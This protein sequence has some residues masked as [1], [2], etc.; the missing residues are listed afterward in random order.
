MAFLTFNTKDEFM[1]I[2]YSVGDTVQLSA[3]DLESDLSLIESFGF[4]RVD[5]GSNGIGGVSLNG[6]NYKLVDNKNDTIIYVAFS[7]P[8]K[9]G[10]GVAYMINKHFFSISKNAYHRDNSQ[11]AFISYHG[12]GKVYEE[13]FLVNGK[14]AP[15][16]IIDGKE[17][18][19]LTTIRTTKN[20]KDYLFKPQK[21][22]ATKFRV[23]LKTMTPLQT[24]YY[25]EKFPSKMIEFHDLKKIYEEVGKLKGLDRINLNESLTPDEMTILEMITF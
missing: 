13:N 19:Y 12:N 21:W 24:I 7:N 18:H 11:P 10:T 25:N 17:F 2:I 8:D 23:N 22:H 16:S 6:I 1:A 9:A 5:Q 20:H 4:T 14:I 3:Q 15:I